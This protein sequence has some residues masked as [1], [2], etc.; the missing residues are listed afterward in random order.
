MAAVN[1]LLHSLLTTYWQ[2]LATLTE[3]LL[4]LVAEIELGTELLLLV[5]GREDEEL[6]TELVS[7]MYAYLCETLCTP[8]RPSF[9][10]STTW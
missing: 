4:R 8:P 6:G 2:L 5:T 7:T 1:P 3:E 9:T 10:V